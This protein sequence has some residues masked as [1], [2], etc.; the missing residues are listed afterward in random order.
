VPF[1]FNAVPDRAAV[2]VFVLLLFGALLFDGWWVRAPSTEEQSYFFRWS[3]N[4]GELRNASL[5]QLFNWTGWLLP[6]L[7]VILFWR[8]WTERN[9][10]FAALGA[11]LLLLT[12]FSLL[13]HAMG[14][15]PGDRLCSQA[16]L[17]ACGHPRKP[18]CFRHFPLTRSRRVGPAALPG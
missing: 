3:L 6:A 8:S 15:L 4:I 18:A 1:G 7:P 2:V 11:V 9:R 17:G 12:G 10:S 5:P 14:I 13:Q 16:P